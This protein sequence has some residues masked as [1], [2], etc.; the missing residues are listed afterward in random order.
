VGLKWFP[1]ER[2]C[3]LKQSSFTKSVQ[4][5]SFQLLRPLYDES[6]GGDGYVSIEVGPELARD[7]EGT[8]AEARKLHKAVG[9]PNLLVKVPATQEGIE[10]IRVL[11][12]EGISVN[13][14]VCVSLCCW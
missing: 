3:L 2:S 11:T 4:T 6:N 14:T 8:L 1:T 9:Q 12:S 10:P 5:F 13:V 7:A